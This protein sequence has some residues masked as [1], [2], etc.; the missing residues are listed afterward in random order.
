MKFFS[1]VTFD[2]VQLFSDAKIDVASRAIKR[3]SQSLKYRKDN[4]FRNS[5]KIDAELQLAV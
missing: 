3:Y 2:T 1:K 5:W 4:K